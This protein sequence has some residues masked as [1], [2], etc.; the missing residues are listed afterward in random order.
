MAILKRRPSQDAEG[1]KRQPHAVASELENIQS[2]PPVDHSNTTATAVQSPTKAQPVFGLDD[3]VS[4]KL[5]SPAAFTHILDVAQP[6]EPSLRGEDPAVASSSS[7][8]TLSS[9]SS[10]FRTS[11]PPGKMTSRSP[12]QDFGNV[13]ALSRF[14]RATGPLDLDE[15]HLGHAVSSQSFSAQSPAHDR[16]FLSMSLNSVPPTSS[17]SRA[18]VSSSDYFKALDARLDQYDQDINVDAEDSPPPLPAKSIRKSRSIGESFAIKARARSHSSGMR[19]ESAGTVSPP[20]LPPSPALPHALAVP[21]P[22]P[23][24]PSAS[25]LPLSTSSGNPQPSNTGN[26]LKGFGGLATILRRKKSSSATATGTS[27]KGNG[28][29]RRAGIGSDDFFVPSSELGL[30]P[31]SDAGSKASPFRFVL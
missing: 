18:P 11:R 2:S 5:S 21:S 22:N 31:S 6:V 19:L 20:I 1:L 14:L 13:R 30:L 16:P 17:I 9:S 8:P 7:A 4:S 28:H 23:A 15:A 29:N 26:K 3:L 12:E 24:P 10:Q 25:P 27:R